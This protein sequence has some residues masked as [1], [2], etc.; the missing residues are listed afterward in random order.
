MMKHVMR[1]GPRGRRMGRV[2]AV[3]VGAAAIAIAAMVG[4]PIRSGRAAGAEELVGPMV[5]HVDATEANLWAWAGDPAPPM[6][7]RWW[8]EEGGSPEGASWVAM[9]ARD[10]EHGAVRARITGLTPATAYRYEVEVAGAVTPTSGGRFAT[11]PAAG[12]PS[13]FR[14]A[15]SSCMK[16]GRYPEQPSFSLLLRERP[17]MHLLLGDVVYANTTDPERLWRAHLEQR[18]VK[19]FAEVLRNV[20]TYAIWDDHDYGSNDSD[21]T[22]PGKERSLRA[23]TEVWANPGAGTEQVPGAFYRFSRG[24]VDF[25][26]LDG[27]YHRSPDAAPNDESKRMLGDAQFEWLRRELIASKAKFKVLASGSTMLTSPAD[28]WRLYDFSRQRLFDLIMSNDIGGVIYLSG[29]IHFTAVVVHSSRTTGGYPVP[30]VISS[31]IAN[32]SQQGFATLDFDTTVADPT[33]RVRIIHGNEKVASDR[34]F[35]LSE[36]STRGPSRDP[37]PSK[38]PARRAY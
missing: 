18:R 37:E 5:G 36:L 32:G 19:Q 30:E 8:A 34:T 33:I 24:E 11:A 16:V 25:F 35:R 31:G 14:I 6:R 23:F 3:A 4:L 15:T 38:S 2:P 12:T 1:G 29:D 7:V 22:E 26:V 20:P 27:R 17:A 10:D 21:G 28:G 9:T 13:A